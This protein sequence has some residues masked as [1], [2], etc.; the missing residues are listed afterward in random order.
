MV[1]LCPGC[2]LGTSYTKLQVAAV[3]MEGWRGDL[4]WEVELWES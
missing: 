2:A 4:L 3:S 1:Q